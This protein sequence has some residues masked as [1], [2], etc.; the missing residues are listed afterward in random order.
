MREQVRNVRVGFVNSTGTATRAQRQ[1]NKAAKKAQVVGRAAL[2]NTIADSSD[3]QP[4]II[5]RSQWAGDQCKPRNPPSYGEVKLAYVHHTATTSD[6]GPDESA[7]QVL[8]ICLFHRNSNG[9]D[10]I[11]YNFLVDKYGTIYEGR[12]GGITAAVIGA[13]AQGFNNVSTGIAALGTYGDNPFPDAGVNSLS[14]L[15]GWKLSL[16]GVPVLGAVTVSSGGG[17]QNRFPYGELVTL[18]HVSGHRDTGK[19]TCP[20]DSLYAQL[21]AIRQQAVGDATLSLPSIFSS[22]LNM[23]LAQSQV[24][25]R[26]KVQFGGQLRQGDGTPIANAEIRVEAR[27][28]KGFYTIIKTRTDG[29]G[30]WRSEFRGR[31]NRTVR[32]VYPGNAEHRTVT[33]AAHEIKVIPRLQVRSRARR[34]KRKQIAWLKGKVDP[35]RKLKIVVE[36]RTPKGRYK[37]NRTIYVVKKKFRIGMK[38][39]SLGLYRLTV[40]TVGDA[41][42]SPTTGKPVYVRVRR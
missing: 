33:T 18:E 19:T 5:P 40:S 38:L 11:G 36:R 41:R 29:N 13:Q 39:R 20:G 10:D 8:A 7:A 4:P 34:I 3:A 9:W 31:S 21:P 12:E 6:Y 27:G 25:Y 16:H 37:R 15:I 22:Q 14:R 23:G 30:D 2:T 32:A 1:R 17:P 24:I 26:R 35:K 28:P 42:L